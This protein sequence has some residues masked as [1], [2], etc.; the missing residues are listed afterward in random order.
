MLEG[1]H[2]KVQKVILQKYLKKYERVVF[3]IPTD[4]AGTLAAEMPG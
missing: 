3:D 2:I 4:V 1:G